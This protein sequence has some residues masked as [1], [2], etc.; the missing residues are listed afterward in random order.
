[1]LG[2][3]VCH[4]VLGAAECNAVCWFLALD[5]VIIHVEIGSIDVTP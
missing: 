5:R 4:S 1:M 3:R 2:A